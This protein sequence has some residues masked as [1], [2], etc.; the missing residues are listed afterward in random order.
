MK[1]WVLKHQNV[2]NSGY[3]TGDS[4]K[5]T[6]DIERAVWFVRRVDAERALAGWMLID[7]QVVEA[8]V[9]DPGIADRDEPGVQSAQ[10]TGL[11]ANPTTRD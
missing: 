7:A 11:A 2:F 5:F 8:S 4:L 1:V 9:P 10:A 3:W 6:T